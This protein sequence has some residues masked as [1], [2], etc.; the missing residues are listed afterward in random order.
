MGK[1]ERTG[2]VASSTVIGPDGEVISHKTYKSESVDEVTAAAIGDEA[3][4]QAKAQA[5][6]NKPGFTESM[7]AEGP[8]GYGIPVVAYLALGVGAAWWLA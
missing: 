6:A 3:L 7:M 5:V 8:L 1:G 4:H 2:A